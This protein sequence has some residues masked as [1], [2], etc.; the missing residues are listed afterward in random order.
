MP[1]VRIDLFEG[2]PEEM[3][4]ELLRR[5][6]ET[7]AEV[8]QIPLDHV[9]CILNDV[10]RRSWSRCGVAFPKASREGEGCPSAP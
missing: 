1:L 7:V 2:R 3:K 5:V 6:A 10:P 8:L 9:Q 4:E